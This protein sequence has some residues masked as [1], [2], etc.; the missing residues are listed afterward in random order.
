MSKALT[1][2]FHYDNIIIAP[3]VPVVGSSV[4]LTGRKLI[5]GGILGSQSA[6]P[7]S[8]VLVAGA[9][10]CKAR[11]IRGGLLT[12]ID[13]ATGQPVPLG[14]A[15]NQPR[16]AYVLNGF[17]NEQCTFTNSAQSLWTAINLPA[18]CPARRTSI[19]SA[20]PVERTRPKKIRS[21]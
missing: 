10:D 17:P 4:T 1:E 18:T 5:L 9:R 13:G 12:V 21:R 16:A 15:Q 7:A 19:A 8:A 14:K 3:S 6:A 2:T 11:E 20:S